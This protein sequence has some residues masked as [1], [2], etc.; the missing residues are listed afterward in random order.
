MIFL[1]DLVISLAHANPKEPEMRTKKPAA[2]DR[3]HETSTEKSRSGGVGDYVITPDHLMFCSER[4][5][6][7]RE[8]LGLPAPGV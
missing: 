7:E 6:Q 5:K 3:D 1:L 4:K 2:A 8:L